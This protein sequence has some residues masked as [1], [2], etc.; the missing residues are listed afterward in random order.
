MK[1]EAE[2]MIAAAKVEGEEIKRKGA[3]QVKKAIR[4]QNPTLHSD[5][6]ENGQEA[7]QSVKLMIDS[8][9]AAELDTVRKR[10]KEVVQVTTSL[11]YELN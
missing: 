8:V 5:V 2:T 11:F 3:E 1:A 6:I 9:A 10:Q 4:N 7:E